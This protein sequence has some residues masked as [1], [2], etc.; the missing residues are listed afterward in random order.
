MTGRAQPADQGEKVLL[1]RNKATSLQGGSK[2]ALAAAALLRQNKP[3]TLLCAV[4]SHYEVGSVVLGL[5][6]GFGG[7]WV[8]SYHVI[9]SMELFVGLLWEL[10]A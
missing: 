3:E 2:T 6:V 4:L 8:F 5:M 1:P 7:I 9:V 10:G